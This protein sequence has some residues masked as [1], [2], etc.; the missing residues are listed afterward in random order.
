MKILIIGHSVEDH[1]HQGNKETIKPGGIYYSALGMSKIISA[2]DEIHLV[3]DLQRSSAHLFSD[4]YDKIL[5]INFCWVN[6]IPK[7][8]LIIHD[9]EERTECYENISKN[10]D[11]DLSM[12]NGFDGILINMITGYDI[13]LE[14][15]KEIRRNFTGL[16]YLDVHS[17]S[18]GI[19]ENKTRVFRP[20]NNFNDWAFC[21]DFIQANQFEVKTLSNREDE[22]GISKEILKHKTQAIVVTKGESGAVVYFKTNE[23]VEQL[24]VSAEKVNTVNKVG[25]GDI[26]GSVFFY[27]YLKTKNIE[28]SLVAANSAAG[29]SA[30]TNNLN[31]LRF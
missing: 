9:E 3:T 25:C 23:T 30:A 11:I 18:R 2:Q 24:S 31:E 13:T 15:L 22:L 17:L 5:T 4:V 28:E 27:T 26:F 19:T 21:A 14:Q 20:I 10:L 6:E 1:I 7:V 16:I 8:H 29:K 12:L